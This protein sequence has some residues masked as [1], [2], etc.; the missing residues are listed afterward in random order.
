M[1]NAAIAIQTARRCQK[2]SG[3]NQKSSGN[4]EVAQ[5]KAKAAKAKGRDRIGPP[6]ARAGLTSIGIRIQTVPVPTTRYVIE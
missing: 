6:Y 2:Y 3:A 4:P 1:N 5:T